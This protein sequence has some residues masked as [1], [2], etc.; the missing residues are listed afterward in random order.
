MWD[1][2]AILMDN[3]KALTYELQF[4]NKAKVGLSYHAKSADRGSKFLR[5]VSRPNHLQH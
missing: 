2:Y 5:N 4:Y 1:K 3:L